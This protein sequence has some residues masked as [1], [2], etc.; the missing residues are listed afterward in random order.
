MNTQK[1]MYKIITAF[2]KRG[3]G[4]YWMRIGS[5]Y[6]NHDNSINLYIDAIPP[7]SSRSRRYELQI[8]ELDEED[9]RRREAH[10]S[11][12]LGGIGGGPGTRAVTASPAMGAAD[13][14]RLPF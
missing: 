10:A 9:L 2:E 13:G 7:P 12:D 1:K 14:E 5:G 6:T 4:Q 8:R 3:G 11:P